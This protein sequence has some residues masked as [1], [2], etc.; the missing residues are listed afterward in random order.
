MIN[1]IFYQKSLLSLL[2]LA[3]F[4]LQGCVTDQCNMNYTH[5]V[6]SPVYMDFGAFRSAV[7]L[8]SPQDLRNPGKIYIKGDILITN[9]VG[10]GVHIINNKNP[11]NP[12]SMAF[13]NV[14]GNYDIGFNCDMMYLDSGPDLLVVDMTDPSNPQLINRLN[15]VLPTMASYRGYHSDPTKGIVT[16]WVREV[17]TEPYD[18][19]TGIPALWEQNR[20]DPTQDLSNGTTRTINPTAAGKAGSMSRFAVSQDHLYIVTPNLLDS[21][22]VGVCESPVKVGSTELDAGSIG[23]GEMVSVLDNL[24]LIGGSGGMAVYDNQAPALPVNLGIFNH[25]QACDPVVAQGQTAYVTLRN[26]RE[27]ACGNSFTNQLD[28]VSLVNPSNPILIKSFD[29]H[30][31][32]GLSIDGDLLFIADG[33][34]GLKVFDAT[35]PERVGNKMIASF[36]EMHGIDVIAHEE[37]LILVGDDGIAQYSYANPKDITL[38]SEM[39]I[40]K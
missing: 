22:N 16:E 39:L 26:G 33:D 12:Q 37:I 3:L 11:E 19:Q 6:Y 9:E 4:G 8:T 14:P 21:Y 18:C 27:Q 38:L 17:K 1:R 5:A 36:P 34:A 7:S 32:H 15:D 25:A 2:V 29:M 10:K 35:I 28:V 40:S 31:P 13:L 24:L 20:V 23:E 30:H